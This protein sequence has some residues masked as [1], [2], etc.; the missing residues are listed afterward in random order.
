MRASKYEYFM[1]IAKQ[2]AMRS[3][4]LSRQVGCIL[5]DEHDHILSTGY[6]GP[7][8]KTPHCTKCFRFESGRD[9]YKCPAVH[10]EMNALLQ[11]KDPMS[12]KT[13]FVTI[14]PC[15]ICLRL[16]ANTSTKV[17]IADQIYTEESNSYFQRYWVD[18][19]RRFSAVGPLNGERLL[20]SSFLF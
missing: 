20:N 4:C 7:A 13:A 9:L 1:G 18:I 8:A 10:A 16:L 17:L 12:I 3:P 2:V 15:E 6:N 5:I 11:C 19:L 14:T